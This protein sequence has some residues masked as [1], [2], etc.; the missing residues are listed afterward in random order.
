MSD[1]DHP[2][3]LGR[4]IGAVLAGIV[5]DVI[6]SVG[7]DIVLRKTG[8]FPPVSQPMHDRLFLLATIYRVIYGVAG[9]YIAARLAPYRPMRHALAA[10]VV[11]VILSTVG[12]LA[13]WNRGPEFGPHWYP[14]ALIVTAMPSAW[15]GGF[16][17][18]RWQVER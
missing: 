12:A 9:C 4:S 7:T 2:R 15:L 11:G 5:A 13:S 18:E 6:L 14:L 17:H 3:R 16:L 10:G 1:T 8:V